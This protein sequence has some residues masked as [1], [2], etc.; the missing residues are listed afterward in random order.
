MTS[1]L[2]KYPPI[3]SPSNYEFAKYCWKTLVVGSLIHDHDIIET[4]WLLDDDASQNIP[5]IFTRLLLSINKDSKEAKKIEQLS[6]YAIS[7]SAVIDYASISLGSAQNFTK[8]LFDV[9]CSK[10]SLSLS[11]FLSQDGKFMHDSQSD[12]KHNDADSAIIENSVKF[13]SGDVDVSYLNTKQDNLE[14]LIEP[15]LCVGSVSY[16]INRKD[17][18]E[19]PSLIIDLKCPQTLFINISPVLFETALIT[20]KL[21][22]Q[23]EPKTYKKLLYQRDKRHFYEICRTNPRSQRSSLNRED[24]VS[25]LKQHWQEDFEG[26][27]KVESDKKIMALMNAA[28][29][30]DERIRES[31]LDN[32]LRNDARC[33]FSGCRKLLLSNNI[34]VS[35]TVTAESD[36]K[37]IEAGST[38]D[39]TLGRISLGIERYQIISGIPFSPYQPTMLKLTRN[40]KYGRRKKRSSCGFAPLLTVVP[41]QQ[42]CLD[43]IKLT[44]R[45]SIQIKSE[46][47]IRVRIVRLPQKLGYLQKRNTKLVDLTKKNLAAALR[48]VVKG[49]LIVHEMLISEE[50]VAAIP[51]SIVLSS[52][53]HALLFQDV[54]GEESDTW[55]DPV[56]LT[57]DFL[58][59]DMELRE[60]SKCHTMS[61]ISIR[62]ERL[63]V[64]SSDERRGNTSKADSARSIWS[65]TAW[66]TTI[67]VV[68]FFL[69]SN[70]MPFPISI[71]TWQYRASD[72]NEMWMDPTMFTDPAS[73]HSNENESDS[74]GETSSKSPSLMGRSTN[75][76]LY[77]LSTGSSSDDY[78]S[79][80]S[81]KAGATLRLCGINLSCP[82]YIQFSQEL[83]GTSNEWSNVA[84][85]KLQKLRTGINPKKGAVSLKSLSI[86]LGDNVDCFIDTTVERGICRGLLFSPFWI[87]NQSGLKLEYDV[88]NKRYLDAGIGGLPI[89]LHCD[90]ESENADK[91]SRR[92]AIS[93]IPLEAPSKK[94]LGQWWDEQ[95]N[96]GL[97]M[98]KHAIVGGDWSEKIEMN[99][100]G[101]SGEVH[102]SSNIVFSVSIESMAGI[103]FRSNVSHFL[104]CLHHRFDRI[105][106]ILFAP[107]YSLHSEICCAQ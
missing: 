69:L 42:S 20:S 46:I 67:T 100:A 3:L 80:S 93:V 24:V 13:C 41:N 56:L 53:Y 33:F 47:P 85:V 64:H 52:H 37:I 21:I 8:P 9:R 60:V 32:I 34:G 103:F 39:C 27:S 25:E 14:Q 7:A 81:L 58:F 5:D 91:R 73:E 44:V 105:L 29:V 10:A 62:K 98:A 23:A 61:G 28:K 77:H 71:K 54:S 31:L 84:T 38:V 76:A 96:G 79:L 50:S 83:R 82:L 72:E 18:D 66:D 16:N 43:E 15:Y 95:R 101:T 75:T 59:N 45:S 36:T 65:R 106:T 107:A 78:Y 2:L 97:V 12:K 70:A 51:L 35:L 68:P 26:Q 55:R 89:M 87:S 17:C 11:A 92:K 63:N 49:A 104:Y 30:D 4:N 74:D 40:S 57:K 86:R 99:A 102:C 6:T 90:Y 48:R 19:K 88:S 1:H 22:S 94:V